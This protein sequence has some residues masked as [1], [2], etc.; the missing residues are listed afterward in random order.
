[1]R[2]VLLAACALLLTGCAGDSAS[3][4]ADASKGAPVVA[5]PSPTNGWCADPELNDKQVTFAS[6]GGYLAG[7]L[8]GDA[9]AKVAL[10]L[11][12]QSGADA[13]SWLGWAKQQAAAGYRVL[14][15]DFNGEGRSVRGITG[16][17]TPSGD[18]EAAAAYAREQGAV[19]VVLI[20]ASRGGTAVL[21]AAARLMPPAAGVVSVS[22]VAE[23][24]HENAVQAAPRLTVPVLYLV[25]K[26]DSRAAD[27][28]RAMYDATPGERR[29]LSVIPGRGHG[30]GL[31]TEGS[32]GSA[33]AS[34][35]IAAFLTAN[36]KPA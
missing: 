28:A 29:T 10:V 3:T 27:D 15:F 7:Y 19:G 26:D 2:I 23:Y 30:R 1:M 24:M 13:C 33:E 22:G 25:A 4:P 9:R 32:D 14:A 6:Q 35:A 31:V 34:A 21:V 20:G 18:V 5:A 12:P 36:A 17:F 11:A 8:L 16:T